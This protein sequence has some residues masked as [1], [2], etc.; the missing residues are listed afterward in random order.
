MISDLGRTGEQVDADLA[1]QLPLGLRD[2]GVARTGEQVDRGDRLG[3]QG[4]RC[5]RL[6]TAE[7]VDLVGA[8][9]VHRGDADRRGSRLESAACSAATR[10]TPATLAVTTVMCA[11]AVSG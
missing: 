1:E 3:A 6:H 2:V 9:E 11:E 7:Q 10:S 5:D 8:G 4:Q